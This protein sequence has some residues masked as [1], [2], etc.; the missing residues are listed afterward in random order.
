MG[1]FSPRSRYALYAE[2]VVARD[3]RGRPV[4]AVMAPDV[5]EAAELGEHLRRGRQRLDH[6]AY[7]YLDDPTGFW[8]IAL[9]NDAVLPDAIAE[10]PVVKIP[11][12]S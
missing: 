2:V 6:L 5:P 3:R 1:I 12:R 4:R 7:F 10:T 9:H 11:V 8:R